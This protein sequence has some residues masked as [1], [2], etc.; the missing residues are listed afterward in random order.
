[1]A[2]LFIGTSG[3]YYKHWLGNFYPKDL[4]MRDMFSFYSDRFNTVEINN[5]FYALPKETTVE[6]W[7]EM[8]PSD[9]CFA[10]KAS[11][12]LTHVK[13]LI[14]P[15]EPLTRYF[16]VMERLGDRLGPV[17][18]QFPRTWKYNLERLAEFLTFLPGKHRYVFEFRHDS[19]YVPAVY[20]LLKTYNCAFCMFDMGG[21]ESPLEITADFIYVRMH[22]PGQMYSG[23]Y[24]TDLLIPWKKRIMAWDPAVK[25]IYFYF[26]NDAHGYAVKNALELKD[27]LGVSAVKSA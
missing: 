18:F 1:M 27:M 3:W 25:S 19:W 8:A 21:K 10:A 6:R 17:L 16:N 12:Y 4:S 2:R 14:E 26:N 23:D 7:A 11:R 15:V 24:R 9:F 20:K 22:S 5:S 13:K